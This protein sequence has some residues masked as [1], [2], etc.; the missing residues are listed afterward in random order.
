MR[1]DAF[2]QRAQ[3]SCKVKEQLLVLGGFGGIGIAAAALLVLLR[4]KHPHR[5]AAN[6]NKTKKKKKTVSKY[7]QWHTR[8][9]A[10]ARHRTL[11]MMLKQ[12]SRTSCGFDVSKACWRS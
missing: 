4:G 3:M 1:G 2:G 5:L 7:V 6:Q 10:Y 11:L 8:F 9:V 12:L